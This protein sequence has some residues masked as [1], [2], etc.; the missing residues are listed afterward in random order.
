MFELSGLWL[1]F[2]LAAAYGTGVFTSQWAKDKVTGVPS[3]LRNALKALEAG[4]VK[5]MASA[6]ARVVTDTASLLAAGKA[7]VAGEPVPVPV[8]VV[9]PP[10]PVEPAPATPAPARVEGV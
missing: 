1:L 4:A 7:A 10:A 6:K 8:P 5:E 2:G 3:D 9:T